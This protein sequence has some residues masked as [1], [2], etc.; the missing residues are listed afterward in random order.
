MN[1]IKSLIALVSLAFMTYSCEDPAGGGGGTEPEAP[2]LAEID[3]V[4]IQGTAYSLLEAEIS[5]RLTEEELFNACPRDTD[6]SVWFGQGLLEKGLLAK[7]KYAIRTNPPEAARTAYITVSGYPLQSVTDEP[8]SVTIPAEYV[9]SGVEISSKLNE[10][11]RIVIVPPDPVG[12]AIFTAEELAS[13][14]EETGLSLEGSY[15][16]ANDIDISDYTPWSV[17]GL[18]N[19]QNYVSM[20]GST[21]KKLPF[22]GTLDGN[23]HKITGLKLPYAPPHYGEV[24][25][26]RSNFKGSGLFGLID[27]GTVKNL[28]IEL[29]EDYKMGTLAGNSQLRFLAGGL[30]G[31][32]DRGSVIGV[33]VR[34]KID[35]P[36]YNAMYSDND[37]YIGGI[38]G[39][40]VSSGTDANTVTISG[41][42]SEVD[43]NIVSK[44]AVTAGGLAG[45]SS[46]GNM[47]IMLSGA[48]GNMDIFSDETSG[49]RY[50]FVGGFTG[51]NGARLS[52]NNASGKVFL[53]VNPVIDAG[54][55]STPKVYLG[56]FTG[57][58]N[59]SI[60]NCSTASTI[61]YS[62][63]E[64][65]ELQPPEMA[66]AFF[67]NND[68]TIKDCEATGTVTPV[69]HKNDGWG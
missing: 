63:K 41:C 16:L 5:I 51:R 17:I 13:I 59:S 14:G 29:A 68:G 56:G 42:V 27:G 28:T 15:Y 24:G 62:L 21:K 3:D 8:L 33:T 32:I 46:N 38:V 2:Q 19:I 9:K 44:G 22:S 36:M 25:A 47:T 54:D 34:G 50:F 66:G 6:I 49:G 12:T 65:M 69:T 60:S 53:K 4:T 57:Y 35:I 10:N 18:P 43:M 40:S 52:H 45:Y 11:A 26:Q 48:R 37:L 1:K 23:G 31:R 7:T 20:N 64:G 67:G 58:N 39:Y 55:N 61:V 30:A